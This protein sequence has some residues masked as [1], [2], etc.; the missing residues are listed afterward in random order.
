MINVLDLS[1]KVCPVC[2]RRLTKDLGAEK[3][4]CTHEGCT[5]FLIKFN[6]PYDTMAGDEIQKAG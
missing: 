2:E 1:R 3:E 5:L 4:W 6:I